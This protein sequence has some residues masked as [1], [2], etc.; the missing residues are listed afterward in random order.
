MTDQNYKVVERVLGLNSCYSCL[1]FM[2]ELG[3]IA[4]IKRRS[5]SFLL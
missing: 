5:P 2:A 1:R 3:L 4:R